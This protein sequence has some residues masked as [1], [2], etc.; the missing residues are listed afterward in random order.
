MTL[1]ISSIA[2][3]LADHRIL[4]CLAVSWISLVVAGCATTSGG[5]A[6]VG[7]P[8]V[9]PVPI[10]AVSKPFDKAEWEKLATERANARWALIAEKKFEE[11]FAFYTDASARDASPAVLGVNMR[12]MRALGG[13]VESADCSPTQC[14][15]SVGVTVL[16]PIPRVGNKQQIIPFKEIWTPEKGTLRLI[17]QP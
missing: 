3:P 5:G 9:A 10:T 11:A 7:K 2:K 15:V 17:R 6:E 12:N 14:E 8:V 16:F 1:E 4:A 13:K